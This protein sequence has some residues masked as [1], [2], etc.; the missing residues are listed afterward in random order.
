MPPAPPKKSPV[1]QTRP[2]PAHLDGVE[3]RRVVVVERVGGHSPVE[4]VGVVEPLRA[5]VV[6]EVVAAVLLLQE[7]LHLGKKKERGHC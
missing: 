4:L 1:G 7:A 5:E 2:P 3:V 6:E